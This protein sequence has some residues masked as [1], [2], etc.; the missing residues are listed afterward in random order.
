MTSPSMA[1]D[2]KQVLNENQI[3]YD[4]EA[5]IQA[6]AKVPYNGNI[7]SAVVGGTASGGTVVDVYAKFVPAASVEFKHDAFFMPDF[8]NIDLKAQ[9][10]FKNTEVKIKGVPGETAVL[11]CEIQYMEIETI[12]SYT[13]VQAQECGHNLV[14]QKVLASTGDTLQNN[15]ELTDKA[16]QTAKYDSY[17]ALE[18]TYL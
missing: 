12:K 14:K 11:S 5:D 17:V 6:A 4:Y 1:N 18:I 2:Y 7:S 16:I 13:P 15:V 9:T 10:Y 3:T 8:D